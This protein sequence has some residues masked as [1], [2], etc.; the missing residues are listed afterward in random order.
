VLSSSE[1][2]E[3]RIAVISGSRGVTGGGGPDEGADKEV[4]EAVGVEVSDDVIGATTVDATVEVASE[5]DGETDGVGIPLV[6]L[7]TGLPATLGFPAAAS[8][9]CFFAVFNKLWSTVN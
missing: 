1:R 7:T 2:A 8:A 6:D 9:F 4:V 5:G 3:R